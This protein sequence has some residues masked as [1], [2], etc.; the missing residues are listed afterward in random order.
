[1]A[2]IYFV[3]NTCK[4]ETRR[5]FRKVPNYKNWGLCPCGGNLSR[6]ATGSN[7][8]VMETLDTGFMRKS[9]TRLS[10]A[11]RLF[12]EREKADPSKKTTEYV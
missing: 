11:E 12:K 7:S 2:L 6:Q 3:C 5:L 8:Q 4:K 10:E 1:M 9:V